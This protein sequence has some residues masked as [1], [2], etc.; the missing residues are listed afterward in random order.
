MR[1][2]LLCLIVL[3]CVTVPGWRATPSSAVVVVQEACVGLGNDPTCTFGSGWTSGNVVVFVGALT[4]QVADQL[5]VTGIV[6]TEVDLGQL[7]IGATYRVY[8]MCLV[9]DGSDAGDTA[10]IM[11]T[12]GGT[13]FAGYGVELSGTDGCTEDAT[14]VGNSDS[15]D[16][17]NL[18]SQ[19]STATNASILLGII[20]SN[21][22]SNFC[23][24]TCAPT[25]PL[26]T[27]A[28]DIA[29]GDDA[30]FAMGGY[31]ITTTAG[32]YDMPFVS[33]A[34][35]TSVLAVYALKAAAVA[36]GNGPR[37]LLLGVC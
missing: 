14:E 10:A 29:A 1:R 23:D 21:S 6:D 4:S 7:N 9:I 19:I 33:A 30:G 5:D 15:N 8:A 13:A 22:M 37:C 31:I 36:G 27:T 12:V 25:N 26:P 20:R 35:E 16:P 17:Y 34:N 3:L 32:S 24:T 18:S 11:T 28:A 2:L